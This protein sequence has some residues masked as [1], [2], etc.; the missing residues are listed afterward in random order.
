MYSANFNAKSVDASRRASMVPRQSIP[1]SS[2]DLSY[3][4]KTTFDADYLVPVYLEECLPGDTFNIR[5]TLFVRMQT[6]VFPVMDNLHLD[7]F[8]FFVPNRIVMDD[9]VKLQGEK[10]KSDTTDYVVPQLLVANNYV[11]GLNFT[12]WD[13]FGLPTNQ[14][15]SVVLRISQLPF[16]AYHKIYNDWFR[17]EN[18]IDP[19]P[20]PTNSGDISSGSAA[21][22][23]AIALHKRAKR[24][25]YFT[26][27]LPW[28]QKGNPVNYIPSSVPVSGIG[29][30]AAALPTNTAT[31][32]FRDTVTP[33][34]HNAQYSAQT[35]VAQVDPVTG[36]PQVFAQLGS[37]IGTTINALRLAFATQALLELDARSGTRYVEALDARWGIRPQDYRLQR[38][39]YLG[40]SSDIINMTP[41]AQT[42]STTG[43]L[44]DLGAV[45]QVVGTVGCN[46]AC[47]EHGFILGLVNVRADLTYTQGV[48]KMW[49]RRTRFDHYEVPFANLGE[50]AVLNQELFTLSGDPAG[51]FGYQERWAE[52]R[53]RWS[54]LTGLF[55]R[56]PALQ[57]WH[58]AEF[59]NSA[60][61]LSESFITSNTPMN[62]VLQA[63]DLAF[64]QQFLLDA[65]HKVRCARH[66]PT[67]SVPATL[68]RF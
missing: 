65:S 38:A 5:S 18:L 9:W 21:F 44:G 1:R 42:S 8:W 63:G 49:T 11:S 33:G 31:V 4:H 45:G 32:N 58:L 41:V 53:G 66:I 59:F 54:E 25:D 68:G 47:Q 61:T 23:Q 12:L 2:F 13:H 28:A 6:P 36:F 27:C 60:P 67:F 35:V 48:R 37:Q 29:W 30:N 40:G 39:E 14:A 20:S 55:A 15:S 16:R 51:V 24:P 56:D 17:D 62:R 7:T 26:T 10:P 50:Q 34:I 22:N 52:Y 3:L 57:A 43:S 19:Y 64:G 46:Y